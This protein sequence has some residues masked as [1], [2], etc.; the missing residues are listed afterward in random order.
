MAL[1]CLSQ[2]NVQQTSAEQIVTAP[3]PPFVAPQPLAAVIGWMRNAAKIAFTAPS[4]HIDVSWLSVTVGAPTSGNILARLVHA[5]GAMNIP[6]AWVRGLAGYRSPLSHSLDALIKQHASE[7]SDKTLQAA[8]NVPPL[9][10]D[11]RCGASLGS[12]CAF[13]VLMLAQPWAMSS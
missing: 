9:S 11:H 7:E 10:L 3:Q 1:P 2:P 13:R 6:W 4:L 5:L 12:A 8:S